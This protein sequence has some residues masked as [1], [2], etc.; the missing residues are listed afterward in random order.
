MA[1]PS[2]VILAVGIMFQS[3]AFVPPKHPVRV[4]AVVT[5][6][7]VDGWANTR[8]G[9]KIWISQ[10]TIIRGSLN[11]IKAPQSLTEVAAELGQRWHCA[12]LRIRKTANVLPFLSAKEEQLVLYDWPA[13]AVAEVIESQCW[14]NWSKERSCV[15]PIVANELK[16]A[17]VKIIAATSRYKTHLRP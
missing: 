11:P 9:G 16:S 14:S 8:V 17:A 5:T 13:N 1:R 15:E 12:T 2:A 4:A 10:H 6:S 7:C 3:D